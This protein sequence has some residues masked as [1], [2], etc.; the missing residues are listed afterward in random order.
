M[1]ETLE[2][3]EDPA[4]RA[5][6]WQEAVRLRMAAV[7]PDWWL[8]MECGQV[9]DNADGDDE[10]GSGSGLFPQSCDGRAAGAGS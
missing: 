8:R 3:T 5:I 9:D 6:R 7:E 2:G 10:S 1:T 4:D